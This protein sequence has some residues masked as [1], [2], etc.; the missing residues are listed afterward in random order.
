[1]QSSAFAGVSDEWLR[2]FVYEQGKAGGTDH[3]T[4]SGFLLYRT[5]MCFGSLSVFA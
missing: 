5:I 1:M 4:D 2:M 3:G